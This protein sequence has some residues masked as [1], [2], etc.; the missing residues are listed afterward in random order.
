MIMIPS[1][2]RITALIRALAISGETRPISSFGQIGIF[3]QGT[4]R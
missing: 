4:A 1:L 2:G 3:E